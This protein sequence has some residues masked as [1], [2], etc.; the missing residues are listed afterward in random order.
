MEGVI[1]GLL[2]AACW[3]SLPCSVISAGPSSWRC[4]RSCGSSLDRIRD[5]TGC[6]EDDSSLM[7]ISN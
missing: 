1:A 2:P 3:M 5:F 7:V 4:L 6:F